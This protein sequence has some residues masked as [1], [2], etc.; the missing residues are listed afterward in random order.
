MVDI[1]KLFEDFFRK[2]IAENVG[3]F[4]E[5]E[6]EDKVAELYDKFGDTPLKELGDI[7]PK[8]Y[9]ESKTAEE[10]TEMLKSEI[11][12][13][14]PVS[15]FLCSAIENKDGVDEF[16]IKNVTEYAND[17][18]AVYSVNILNTRGVKSVLSQYVKLL[19]GDKISENLSE[20]MTEILSENA[21]L[22]K[23]EVISAYGKDKNTD[24]YFIEVLSC[25]SQDERVFDIL[26]REFLDH[27][28][29]ISLYTS[30]LVKYGDERA[31]PY[32]EKAIREDGVDYADFKELKLAIESFGGECD[33]SP[34]FSSDEI[35]KKIKNN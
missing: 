18:L 24:K 27:K 32:L 13:G 25:M 20:L 12:N 33:I 34:D 16:L 5:E 2:F 8:A 17:E 30:Y 7:S 28:S 4:T 29:E 15:D 31:L 3:K 23:E 21:D 14:M 19:Q 6:L 10:L 1:D 22:V 26:I 9:F 35:Y 11:E